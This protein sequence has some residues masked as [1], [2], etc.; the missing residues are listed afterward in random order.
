MRTKVLS[1]VNYIGAKT[2][3]SSVIAAVVAGWFAW[4]VLPVTPRMTILPTRSINSMSFSADGRFVACTDG[5]HTSRHKWTG[6]LTVWDTREARELFSIPYSQSYDPD[7]SG[8]YSYAFS[9]GDDKL[10]LYSW[11]ETKFHLLPTGKEWKPERKLKFDVNGLTRTGQLVIGVDGNLY[12]LIHDSVAKTTS[13]HDLA[14]GDEISSWGDTKDAPNTLVGG[15]I[16]SVLETSDVGWQLREIPSGKKRQQAPVRTQ[17]NSKIARESHT[18]TPDGRTLVVVDGKIRTYADGQETK[19]DLR[20]DDA[21]TISPDGRML[22]ALVVQE[23]SEGVLSRILDN[24]RMRLV[25]CLVFYDLATSAEV[26]RLPRARVAFF[27]RDGST[28]LTFTDDG[29]EVYDWPLRSPWGRIMGAAA[30]GATSVFVVGQWLR[31]RTRRKVVSPPASRGE[32][33]AECRT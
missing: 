30:A 18:A 9:P 14:T 26:G 1:I 7:L 27:S 2:I 12:V 10:V 24:L 4:L 13:V 21:P 19:F 32:V 17:V 5:D 23:R 20:A 25:S 28:V 29:V 3:A 6:V 11:G 16:G 31:W 15:M 22:G 8:G 33:Q